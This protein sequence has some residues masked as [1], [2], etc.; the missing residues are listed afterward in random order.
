MT[1]AFGNAFW[2]DYLGYHVLQRYSS[3]ILS[4]GSAE[5]LLFYF[6]VLLKRLG[7]WYFVLLSLLP[8]IYCSYKAEENKKE[9]K[10]LSFWAIFI[11]VFFS[12]SATKLHHYIFPFYAPFSLLTAFAIYKAYEKKSVFLLLAS[13]LVFININRSVILTIS[14]FGEARALL[15]AIL[16]NIFQEV[17][18]VYLSVSVV[19]VIFLYV[20]VANK[21]AGAA[22]SVLII[23]SFSI[24]L[25]FSPERNMSAKKIGEDL[26]DD[27]Q[28]KKI[29]IADIL[30]EYNFEGALYYYYVFP[31]DTE[32]LY[33]R[34][35]ERDAASDTYCLVGGQN[36][37]F[38]KNMDYDIFLCRVVE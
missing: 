17:N 1:L 28:V 27:R 21:A 20:F 31:V 4:T 10:L 29:F 35:Y 30:R 5:D 19:F 33:G 26:G 22:I 11:F 3:D 25:P 32:Y 18:L 16:Y 13:S 23:F 2:R 24:L 6:K 7:S 34:T 36:Y 15:P 38:N 14:D 9:I 12:L 37:E 8:V